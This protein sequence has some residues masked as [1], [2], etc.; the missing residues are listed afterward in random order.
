M[1]DVMTGGQKS[2]GQMTVGQKMATGIIF[3]P[4]AEFFVR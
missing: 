2:I 3:K 1:T 4:E